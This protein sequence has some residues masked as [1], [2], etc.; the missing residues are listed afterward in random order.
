MNYVDIIKKIIKDYALSSVLKLTGF[1]KWIASKLLKVAL[2]SLDAIFDSWRDNVQY[3]KDEAADAKR[4]EKLE[5]AI[6]QKLPVNERIKRESD[7][8][9]G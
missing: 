9:N 6:E 2:K 5:D 8:L 4:E 7:M 1:K 3:K